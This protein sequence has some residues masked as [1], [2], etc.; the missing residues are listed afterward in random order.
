[1]RE[2]ERETGQRF[3]SRARV[4]DDHERFHLSV[5]SAV[6]CAVCAHT[7]KTVIKAV[8]QSL[9]ELLLHDWEDP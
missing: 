5:C 2:A 1:M 9:F 6:E 8:S 3:S 4:V 7:T